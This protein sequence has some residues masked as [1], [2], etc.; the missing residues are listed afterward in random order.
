LKVDPGVGCLR[1]DHILDVKEAPMEESPANLNDDQSQRE[2]MGVE[3][4]WD[5]LGVW[6]EEERD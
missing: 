5:R 1:T 3:F 4:W 2:H 6:D